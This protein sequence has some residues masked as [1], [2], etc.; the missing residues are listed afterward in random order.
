MDKKFF[1]VW[2]VGEGQSLQDDWAFTSLE[3][4]K[5][6]AS[7]KVQYDPNLKCIILEAIAVVRRKDNPVEIVPL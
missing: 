1:E 4:A 6:F 2:V 7:Q 5:D 3:E